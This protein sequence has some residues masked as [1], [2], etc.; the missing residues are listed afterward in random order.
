MDITDK[1]LQHQETL[2]ITAREIAELLERQEVIQDLSKRQANPRQDILD[3]LLKRQ[4][5]AELCRRLDRL[6]PADIAYILEN[7]NQLLRERL[8]NLIQPRERAAILI[9]LDSYI[10]DELLNQ[11]RK[12]DINETLAYMDA[13][14]LAEFLPHLPETMATDLMD[15]LDQKQRQQIQTNLK[16]PRDSVGSLM[17]MDMM[18]IRNDRKLLDV[19]EL[20]RAHQ[21]RYETVDQLYVT[22]KQGQYQGILELKKILFSSPEKI[23]SDVINTSQLTFYT[24]DKISDAI[25]AFERYDLYSAPVLNIHNQ[26][27]GNLSVN[28][29]MDYRDEQRE[30]QQLKSVGLSEE[31]GISTPVWKSAHNRW[32]WLGLNLITAFI[33]SRVIGAYEDTIAHFAALAALMP[34]VASVGG[35]TGNQ[36]VALI[37]RGISLSKVNDDNV[38]KYLVKELAVSLVN[39]VIFGIAVAIFAYIFYQNSILAL[40]MLAALIGN[41]FIAALVGVGIPYFLHIRGRDPVMGSS[42]LLTAITDSMGFFI[43]LGLASLFLI[44]NQ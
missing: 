5:N 12:S 4:Q 1:K 24:D 29:L 19:M 17:D 16:F 39:G 3:T 30:I 35:N 31:E 28:R 44:S 33:A 14:Q 32:V 25:S 42:V 18:T 36:T 9:E 37:I 40:V 27:V 13:T 23:V 20:L 15:S 22:D 7:L 2:Q 26:I 6:H 8:W 43:F 34:I 21:D 38:I 41:L 11:M 10:R